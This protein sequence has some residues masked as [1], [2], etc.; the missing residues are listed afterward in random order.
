M[1]K[2][3][4]LVSLVFLLIVLSFYQIINLNANYGYGDDFAQYILQSQSL[5]VDS[6]DE[7]MLQTDLNSYSD[8]QIGPNAYPVGFPLLL[9]FIS[10]FS[11]EKF[12]YYKIANIFLFN[13]FII[14]TFLIVS[15]KSKLYGLLVSL[16]LIASEEIFM[17]S[18]S[19]ES[20]LMFSVFCLLS[21]Y[22]FERKE[23]IKE[24]KIP[25]IIAFLSLLIKVQ[26]IILIF[27][28]TIIY[29]KNNQL[30]QYVKIYAGFLLTYLIVY[31]SK[32]GYLF[33]EYKDH[34][35]QF[36]PFFKNT[37][38]NLKILSYSITPV[39]LS[40][41]FLIYLFSL[42]IVLILLRCILNI[43]TFNIHYLFIVSYFSFY[44]VY[45]NQQGIRFLLLLVPSI[46]VVLFELT[47]IKIFK[48]NLVEMVLIG[49]LVL[50]LTFI[51][52]S[53]TA[54][55]NLAF[56]LESKELYS[57]LI[58]EVRD[59]EYIAFQKPRLLRLATNK[60]VF[61]LDESSILKKPNYIVVRKDDE[62]NYPLEAL[63]DFYLVDELKS[64]EIYKINN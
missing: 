20:D 23:L 5:F 40:L 33:G 2:N 47:R 4:E 58:K 21:L 34:I 26:G 3:K 53:K 18:N 7:Y 61:Y 36:S 62:K 60:K 27:V 55:Q 35:R 42:L 19:I 48:I 44:S 39:E 43:N 14:L 57:Y 51:N 46:F 12:Q 31:F 15:K 16:L 37:L 49:L 56:N 63:K 59:D 9:K 8:V 52:I 22:F 10:F 1:K 64:Y 17:L 54:P 25:L 28:L 13:V 41:D 32:Y 24:S 38:Y 45:L 11:G 30:K 6:I 50:N 29:Y